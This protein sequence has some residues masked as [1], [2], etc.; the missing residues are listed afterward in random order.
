VP[1]VDRRLLRASRAARA[2][3]VWAVLLGC[4]TA[5]AIVVQ[6][7]LLARVIDR[8]FLGGAS[9]GELQGELLALGV[10]IALRA[11]LS[12]GFE[13]SGRF[14]AARAMSELRGRLVDHLLRARPGG[15]RD[16]RTGELAAAA[17]QGIDSL[18]SYFARYLPQLV[19]A[20]LVPPAIL[21]YL[22]FRDPLAAGVLAVSL[23]LIPLFMVFIGRSAQD[24]TRARWRSLVVLSGH[25]LDVVRGLDTLR[26][27]DRAHAQVATIATASDRFR[28]ETMGTLRIAFMSALV[29]ELVAMMGTALVA[30]TVGVQLVSGA[31]ALTVGLTVLLLA[32]E[33]FAPLRQLGAQFHATADG[34]A[35]AEQIFEIVQAPPALA[36]AARPRPAPDPAR[37]AVRMEQVSFAYPERGGLVLDCVDLELEPGERVA[38]VGP[39]GSGKSTLAALLVRLADP[40]SGRVRCGD[41]DLRDL[42]PGEWRRRIA[43]VPQRPTLFAGSVADNIRL[44]APDARHERVRA[45]AQ[46]ANALDFIGTLPRGLQTAIGEGG[47]PLSAGQ[48]QRIALARAFLRDAPLLVLDEPTAHLDGSAAEAVAEAVGRLT[49]GRTTL[50]IVH[51]PA[52]AARADRVVTLEAGRSRPTQ[53]APLEDSVVAA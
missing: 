38:L 49:V 6:A 11:A 8:A 42:D 13:L 51:H 22:A 48:A 40:T 4:G 31:L 25:F 5:A 27:H 10:V 39:N 20:A 30:A 12:A 14:G 2:H 41:V 52:L 43:W 28:E 33:L 50:L 44:G 7:A 1:A 45:A 3:L 18:E 53:A 36:V 24:R 46:A 9:L 29:L 23:P 32:P 19:L 15:P 47:R 21:L 37:A 35:A 17:V 34:L 26:A 16:A